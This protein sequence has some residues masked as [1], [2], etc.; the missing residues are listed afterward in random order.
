MKAILAITLILA[1]TGCS[2]I[3]DG[4]DVGSII[5]FNRHGCQTTVAFETVKVEV[6]GHHLFK[7]GEIGHIKRYASPVNPVNV[8]IVNGRQ[9]MIVEG[10]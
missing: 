7:L 4:T 9:Y 10:I 2:D 5:S 3:G 1:L 6:D 8:L